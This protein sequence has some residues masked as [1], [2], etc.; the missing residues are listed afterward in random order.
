M[1][2]LFLSELFFPHGGGAEFATYLYA[3]LLS[4]A[5]YDVLVITNRFRG[6]SDVYKSRNL[7]IYRLPLLSN[8]KSVKFSIL[9]RLDIISSVFMRKL[10]RWANMVYVPRF[11]FSAIPFAKSFGKPVITHLHDYIP[12][13]PLATLYDF[14]TEAV[15]HRNEACSLRCIYMHEKRK[16]NFVESVGSMTLNF[17]A[18]YVLRRLL[19]HSD[20]IV[21]VSRAQK[22]I[23]V[24]HFPSFEAKINVIHN[25]LPNLSIV[26]IEGQDFGYFGGPNLLKGFG[27][28]VHALAHLDDPSVLVHAANFPELKKS[29]AFNRFGVIPHKRISDKNMCAFY[30]QIRAVVFP[31]VCPEPLPYVVAEAILRGRIVIGSNIG[32]VTEQV[33]GCK[34]CF[35]FDAGAYSELA[36]KLKFVRSLSEEDVV[37]LGARNREVFIKSF[38][39]ER[40]LEEFTSL[41]RS[42]M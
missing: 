35:L 13:C 1:R 15:C 27:V 2:I 40:V 17:M 4:K 38:S 22:K 24:K 21:C 32:G 30:R 19:E 7:T 6:E 26:P 25:P 36:E 10:L 41:S 11:W 31:S 12:I 9:R 3:K 37:D 16:M 42:L 8:V 29:R 18:R 23:I 14:S 33:E 34:G 39:N 20:A 5:G 28:L